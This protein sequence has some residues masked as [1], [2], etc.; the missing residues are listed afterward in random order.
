MWDKARAAPVAI[1]Q[2]SSLFPVLT[3][4]AKLLVGCRHATVPDTNQQQ[5]VIKVEERSRMFR[6]ISQRSGKPIVPGI[7][8]F[9]DGRCAVRTYNGEEVERFLLPKDVQVLLE[10][11][12]ERGLYSISSDSIKR[13]IEK[14]FVTNPE[15]VHVVVIDGHEA[16]IAARNSSSKQ[17]EISCYALD[18][19]LKNYSSVSELRT[20]KNCVE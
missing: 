1:M 3:I 6:V 4:L 7:D 11:F 18:D 15:T 19:Q 12:E 16:N 2:R 20:V 10:F 13:A 14:Q 8:I 5:P 9:A 17:V